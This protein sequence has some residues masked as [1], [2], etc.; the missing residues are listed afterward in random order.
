M[1]RTGRVWE[2]ESV[3]EKTA[4]D[5]DDGSTSAGA[6]SRPLPAWSSYQEEVAAFFRDLGLESETN[7]RVEG[8]R[9]IH[10]LDVLVSFRSAG[11]KVTWVVECKYWSRPIPK[12]RVL[13]LAG[14]MADVGADRGLIVAESG[15]QAGAVRASAN[16]NITLTSLDDLTAHTADER[17]QIAVAALR[18]RIA[19]LHELTA[20]CWLWAPPSAPRGGIPI[21][22]MI[23]FAGK[24]FELNA[25]VLPRI[26][27][28]SY[29]MVVGFD[30]S[31][32]SPVDGPA[33]LV[34]VLEPRV[35]DAE[36]RAQ[37]LLDVVH[38]AA[39]VVRS[40][41][42]DLESTTG[43]L[44][45][46][47]R[48]LR[49]DLTGAISVE[50]ATAFVD[51]MKLTGAAAGELK[52]NAPDTVRAALGKLMRHLINHTYDI[53]GATQPDWDVEEQVI[54]AELNRIRHAL[55]EAVIAGSRSG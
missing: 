12:E 49:A 42:D 35:A 37:A 8:A 41:I 3:P 2:T 47:G 10:D 34:E 43:N 45:L 36:R 54:S 20:R 55:D 4:T 33:E 32:V 40:L 18:R 48:A 28:G 39:D 51:A 11:I 25:L 23:D 52:E 6:G 30:G 53:A 44:L 1:L 50:P 46:A 15:Y 31:K 16:A 7:V 22:Q 24:T 38:L 21:N 29:P 14:V 17:N 13:V 19:L 5:P 26:I 27:V 9:G